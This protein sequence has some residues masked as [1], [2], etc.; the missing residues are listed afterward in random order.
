MILRQQIKHASS[1]EVDESIRQINQGSKEIPRAMTSPGDCTYITSFSLASF[2]AKQIQSYVLLLYRSSLNA[3]LTENLR[4]V[5]SIILRLF[6]T[7]HHLGKTSQK[8]FYS[9][10]GC[11]S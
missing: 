9:Q 2:V 7:K 10:L 5:I 3:M 8:K 4:N 11:N 1:T 6:L